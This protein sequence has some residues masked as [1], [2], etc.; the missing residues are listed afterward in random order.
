M[1]NYGQQQPSTLPL[2]DFLARVS[3]LREQITLLK[4]SYLDELNSLHFQAL[5]ATDSPDNNSASPRV[6]QKISEIQAYNE[7]I[8]NQIKDLER[9]ALGT[10]DSTKSTKQQQVGN[11]KRTFKDAL[12]KFKG[13][14]NGFRQRTQEQLSR[15]YRIVNPNASEEEVKQ[16]SE[17]DWGSGVFQNAVSFCRLFESPIMHS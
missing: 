9:D 10:Q 12:D 2:Q 3:N 16:A 11:L 15:Q 6:G 14:E 13:I 5:S 8:K 1:Q 4:D 7:A 17:A